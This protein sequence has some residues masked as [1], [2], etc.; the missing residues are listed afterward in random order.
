VQIDYS[1]LSD[2]AGNGI[3]VTGCGVVC[4]CLRA[5][6]LYARRYNFSVGSGGNLVV[7]NC[8]RAECVS[9]KRYGGFASE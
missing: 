6:F 9:G 3:S 1:K 2:L 8:G 5:V 7:Y 4:P